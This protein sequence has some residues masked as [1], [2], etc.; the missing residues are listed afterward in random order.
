MSLVSTQLFLEDIKKLFNGIFKVLLSEKQHKTEDSS[1]IWHFFAFRY[2][3]K[4]T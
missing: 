1:V 4:Q 2:T 3:I